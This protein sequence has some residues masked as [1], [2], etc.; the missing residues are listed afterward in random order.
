VTIE[1]IYVYE[2]PTFQS[3]RIGHY[4]RDDIIWLLEGVESLNK[5]AR[6]RRWYRVQDGYVHSAYV[7][8]VKPHNNRLLASL[9]APEVLGEITHPF[10]QTYRYTHSD[11]W[12]PLY[13][14]YYGSVHCL[15]GIDN[16]P[17]GTPHYRITDHRLNVDYHAA[18]VAVRPIPFD[19]YDPISNNVP[20]NEKRIV[21][22]IDSQTLTAYEGDQAVFRTPVSTGVPTKDLKE[23]EIP[24][25]TPQGSFRVRN[26]I[27][28][29]HMGNGDLTS[30]VAAYELPGVPWTMIFHEDGFAMH[31]AYWHNNFGLRM[32]HGCVNL[33]NDAAK[34]LFRWT[35]PVYDPADWY[36]TGEGTLVTIG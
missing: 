32:S 16:G 30:E 21:I 36:V 31:G 20:S 22:L 9:P 1:L 6:N 11:G 17:D 8:P 12:Q 10:T 3:Q 28:S 18:A 15:T 24:T 23:G 4:H 27:P 13:R 26:K 14:L 34:W 2:Q 29:R 35:T 25:D 7:Q 33:P 5:I 19:E